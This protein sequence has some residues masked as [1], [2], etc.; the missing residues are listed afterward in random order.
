[1]DNIEESLEVRNSNQSNVNIPPRIPSRINRQV[2][3]VL[4]ELPPYIG[5]PLLFTS[6]RAPRPRRPRKKIVQEV[7]PIQR[8]AT[9]PVVDSVQYDVLDLEK[10][11]IDLESNPHLTE[12]IIHPE[13]NPHV[14]DHEVQRWD[15]AVGNDDE[16]P[17]HDDLNPV[18]NNDDPD[19]TLTDDEF[20]ES[21][22]NVTT[23]LE[24]FISSPT[25]HN[26]ED[27]NVPHI[28]EEDSTDQPQVRGN[29]SRGPY[30]FEIV[31]K[32]LFQV[33]MYVSILKN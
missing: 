24:N 30:N 6:G 16:L 29:V 8:E 13:C 14:G 28:D 3:S 15:T 27:S 33:I 26:M 17:H 31:L 7:D 12:D 5:P 10:D 20:F 25:P 9:V 19:L 32:F 23:E 2:P 11:V 22:R 18:D 21:I 1:M 4:P